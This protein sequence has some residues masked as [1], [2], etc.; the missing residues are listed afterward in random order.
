MDDVLFFHSSTLR[1]ILQGQARPESYVL[2][3]NGITVIPTYY[4]ELSRSSFE[5]KPIPE[6]RRGN[7]ERE[8]QW[9]AA[10]DV[11]RAA[12]ELAGSVTPAEPI[13]GTV[14]GHVDLSLPTSL[15]LQGRFQVVAETMMMVEALSSV[16]RDAETVPKCL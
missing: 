4:V 9:V 7:A 11:A 16:R 15:G 14:I 10:Q 5:E 13:S 1:A 12:A 8:A 3:P 2:V 6:Q